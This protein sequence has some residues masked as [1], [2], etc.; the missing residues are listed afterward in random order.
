MDGT[1]IVDIK[2]Y[3][4]YSD[5]HEEAR[6][7]IFEVEKPKLSVDIPKELVDKIIPE[8]YAALVSVLKE[9]PRPSYQNDPERVYG[10]SFGGMNVRFRVED[11][12]LTVLSVEIL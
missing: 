10:L 1:P 5:S 12:N 6:C 4:P 2:P 7:G 9:D 3:L 8:K 11:L